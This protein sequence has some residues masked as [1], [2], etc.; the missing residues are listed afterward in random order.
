MKPL[1]P[2]EYA[3]DFDARIAEYRKEIDDLQLLQ[4]QPWRKW[5][6]RKTYTRMFKGLI[7]K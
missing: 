4:K 7:S 6:R 5:L 2:V 3:A 1:Y